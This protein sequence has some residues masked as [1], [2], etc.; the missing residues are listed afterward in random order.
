MQ[1]YDDFVWTPR[2]DLAQLA[3][4]PTPWEFYL[5]TMVRFDTAEGAG[6]VRPCDTGRGELYPPFGPMHVVTAIQPDPEP[7]C[8]SRA[9]MLVLDHF[10]HDAGIRSMPAVGSSF[11][12][13][14]SED[15]R[16]VFGLTDHESRDLGVRFGQVAVFAWTGP[17][18]S[19]LACVGDRKVHRGWRW[20]H[21]DSM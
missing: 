20:E 5:N 16:A 2:H 11:T 9:R 14:H 7:D 8:V 18:W 4:G 1:E 17:R 13:D 19:L 10:L 12:G 3:Q 15:S 21:P 6:V